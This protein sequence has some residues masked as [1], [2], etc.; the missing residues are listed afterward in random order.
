MIPSK[1]QQAIFDFVGN[2]SDSLAVNAVAGS[3]KSTTVKKSLPLFD[4]RAQI[5]M[6][7]FNSDIAKSLAVGVPTNV[8]VKTLNA[9]GWQV[10]LNNIFGLNRRVNK[11]KTDD[12]LEKFVD[13]TAEK[14]RFFSYLNPVRRLVGLFKANCQFTRPTDVQIMNL[15]DYHGLE[16]PKGEPQSFLDTVGNVYDACL[17]LHTVC[18]FDDQIFFPL[19]LN[20]PI[21]RSNVAIIDEFQDLNP[22]QIDMILKISDRIFGVGD[23]RQSIYGF[24]GA[25]ANAFAKF[26]SAT[27]AKELPLSICYRCSKAVVR[28]AQKIVP[29]IEHAENAIEGTEDTV[30]KEKYRNMVAERDFVLCRTT[31]PLVSECLFMIRQGRK[32]IVKGREIGEQLIALVSRI[33]EKGTQDLSIFHSLLK[34][35]SARENERLSRT[36][37][38]EAI[39]A[40]ND[41]LETICV[42]IE[43]TDSVDG[44]V[45]RIDQIFSNLTPDNAIIFSTLHKAKGLETKRVWILRPDLLPHPASKQPHQKEQEKNLEYVGITRAR[46]DLFWV[47]SGG[48]H[49]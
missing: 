2:C 9:F 47:S 35:Y 49:A 24:R 6:G 30:T 7:A 10:C 12:M 8:V 32:A 1:Y 3:G 48:S 22:I 44:V 16:M 33:N 42:L 29:Y 4:P 43:S 18:D 27:N 26:I 31:A 34:A 38:E 39:A 21:P 13:K 37:N 15:L 41:R 36:N 25:D 45:A 46:E 17:R 20:L 19:Y 11:Y 23:P 14:A 40:L 28:R 5:Y